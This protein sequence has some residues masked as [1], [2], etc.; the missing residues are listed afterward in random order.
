MIYLS[1]EPF[2]TF[3]R[4]SYISASRLFSTNDF[5]AFFLPGS[6]FEN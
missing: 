6:V 5:Y 3:G 1:F 2:G 4:I